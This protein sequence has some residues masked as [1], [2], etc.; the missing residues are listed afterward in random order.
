[1]PE[2]DLV[3]QPVVLAQFQKDFILEVYDN[4]HGTDTAILSMARKNAKTGTIA[5]L[6]LVHTVGPEALQNSRIISGAMS[7]E[8]AAEVYNLASKCVGLSPDLRDIIKIIPSSK[9]LIGMPMNVEYQA[10][11]AEG[12]TAHGKSPIL[13][14]LDEVGQI[15]GA[16]SDF[17]DAITTAQGAYENPLLVY[18]STQSASDSDFLSIAI[19][20]ALTNK[21]E[22]TVCHVYAADE[23][24]E[25]M[26]EDQWKKANPALGMFRYLK[27]VRKM[28]DKAARMPSFE[29]T[30]RN[31]ILNQ[32]VSTVAPFVSRGVWETCGEMPRPIDGR[33]VYAGLDLSSRTDLTAL[34]VIGQ[35]DEGVWDVWPYFWG[36]EKGLFERSKADR[37]PY[38]IWAKQGY[39]MTTP[40]A[41]VDYGFVVQ[42]MAEI[43]EFCEPVAVGYDRWRIDVLKRDA[44]H[45]GLEFPLLEY[46][47]G[48]KDMAPALD[49]LESSLLNGSIRHGMHPV[50]TMCAANASVVKDPAGNRK[51]DKSRDTGRIDGMQALAIAFG[52]HAK[53]EEGEG[54]LS[55]FFNNPLIL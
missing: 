43:F 14:I 3:G 51:L 12:K 38:D 44:E 4:P 31:L 45:L 34:V 19:D 47:Q 35:D 54:D 15:R 40:G 2:G 41:T 25:L 29:N 55:D 16:Q 13:A 28:A 42:Q 9:K 8:Q 53:C 52:A 21:P 5:F 46:G 18:I 24:G 30:F 22:K 6:V 37:Q 50:L 32:R 17:V 33:E 1:M 39:M 26:D 27:D 11:S 23:D 7:R 48:F 36:P 49:N 20:D 10:I